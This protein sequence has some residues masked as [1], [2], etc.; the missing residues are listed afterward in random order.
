MDAIRKMK[1]SRTYAALFGLLM[2]AFYLFANE[3]QSIY[4]CIGGLS[5]LIACYEE[6]L[7]YTFVIKENID[8]GPPTL[9]PIIYYLALILLMIAI[10]FYTAIHAIH[11]FKADNNISYTAKKDYAVVN[12][13]YGG[14]KVI[15]LAD[16]YKD[17]PVTVIASRAFVG[18]D[19]ATKV[20]FPKTLREI[21]NSSFWG[22][23]SLTEITL[24]DGL[25]TMGNAAFRGCKKLKR[26]TIPASVTKIDRRAVS[27]C[28][29]DLVIVGCRGS[30][31]EAFA[32]KAKFR[33]EAI[34]VSQE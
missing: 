16:S 2:L 5:L 4:L 34:S 24:P 22:C 26:I 10:P 19:K 6:I 33:F 32:K 20:V 9:I 27:G 17:K 1:R 28:P 18:R 25:E 23:T 31:A 7:I 12:R 15:K 11:F 8:N 14:D 3:I 29:K 21:K 30:E 13:I